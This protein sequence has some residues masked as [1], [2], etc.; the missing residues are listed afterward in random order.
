MSGIIRAQVS[1]LRGKKEPSDDKILLGWR[2]SRFQEWENFP[3]FRMC[4]EWAYM[5]FNP[6]ET[7]SF[8]YSVFIPSGFMHLVA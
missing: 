8:S 1:S 6:A 7:R 3:I 2:V 4:E 5:H